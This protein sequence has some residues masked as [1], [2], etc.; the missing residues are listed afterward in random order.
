MGKIVRKRPWH[1]PVEFVEPGVDPVEARRRR[2]TK[3][4]YNDFSIAGLLLPVVALLV[5]GAFGY[6]RYAGRGV[7]EVEAEA[8]GKAKPVPTLVVKTEGKPTQT[9][10]PAPVIITPTSTLTPTVSPSS[11]PTPT[12]SPTVEAL[13]SVFVSPVVITPT[14]IISPTATPWPY[15]YEIIAN[16]AISETLYPYI[17]GWIVERDGSTPRPVE[18]ELRFP[19][20]T[21]AFPRPNHNDVATGYYEFLVSPGEYDLALR[22]GPPVHISVG[23]A[24][25]R[26]EV[27][28]RYLNDDRA[29]T[30]ARSRPW[31]GPAPP[32]DAPQPTAA[33]TPTTTATPKQKRLY[34]PLIVHTSPDN[35]LYLPVVF[36]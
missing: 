15:D 4:K 22:G 16:A 33:P 11:T 9:A 18:I 13:E 21:M 25:A 34:L 10:L 8:E 36:R 27:S 2:K 7:F 14:A 29:T 35:A 23:A 1:V 26:Y 3:P 32:G 19:T 28:L 30:A 24:P 31:T 17:S 5:L 6:W 20:G 12:V